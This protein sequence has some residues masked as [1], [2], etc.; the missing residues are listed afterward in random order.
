MTLAAG[1]RLGPR[2][3]WLTLLDLD[4]SFDGLR[5]DPRFVDISRRVRAE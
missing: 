4:L 5:D 2:S 1:T 3:H